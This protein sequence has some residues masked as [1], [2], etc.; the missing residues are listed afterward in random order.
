MN[1]ETLLAIANDTIPGFGFWSV[2]SDGET[3]F[4]T[5]QWEREYEIDL[6]TGDIEQALVDAVNGAHAAAHAVSAERGQ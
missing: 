2:E 4:L 6:E 5:D 3:A 1:A